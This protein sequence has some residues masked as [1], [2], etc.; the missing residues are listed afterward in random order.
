MTEYYKGERIA[1][2]LAEIQQAEAIFNEVDTDLIS[3]VMLQKLVRSQTA[4]VLTKAKLTSL[5]E[6]NND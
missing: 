5:Q 2:L 6:T 1:E 4:V 3:T